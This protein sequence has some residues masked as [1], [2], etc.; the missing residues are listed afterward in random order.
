M[1]RLVNTGQKVPQIIIRKFDLLK[2]GVILNNCFPEIYWGDT[3]TIT[4]QI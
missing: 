1:N 2:L 4:Q 3:R